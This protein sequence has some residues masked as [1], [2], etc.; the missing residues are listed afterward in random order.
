MFIVKTI[1]TIKFEIMMPII[2]REDQG[3]RKEDHRLINNTSD[4]TGNQ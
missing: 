3:H 1:S 4:N 2:I